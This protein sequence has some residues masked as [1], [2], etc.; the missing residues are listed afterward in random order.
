MDDEPFVRYLEDKVKSTI[1]KYG[2][3]GGGDRV[4]V[5]VSGGKDSTTALYVLKKL[6]Y[7]VE[8]I[9]IDHLLGEYSRKNLSNIQS[10][11]SECGIKLH[12][13]Y[14]REE[15]GYSTCYIKSVLN[16]K[17]VRVNQ[18]SI[19]GVMRR[20]I[21][22]RKARE[23]KASKIATGHNLDDE[24]QTVLMNMLKGNVYQSARLGPRAGVLDSGK[25]VPRIKPLY[26]CLEAETERYSRIHD[27]PVVYEPC[28]CSLDSFRTHVKK[29][30][31]GLEEENPG[32]KYS[33]INSFLEILPDLKAHESGGAVK[34]CEACG[35]PSSR[36]L[37]RV[38]EITGA[39]RSVS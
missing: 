32:V 11:C 30:L 28:P 31:N 20:S 22:N 7:N 14:M 37:C 21:L 12:V 18:C 3:I 33:I 38:C 1:E 26:F 35:E 8:G 10:F 19:C 24:V 39:M 6:G 29:L 4:L 23:L 2:L 13:V 34:E 36:R 15:Y 25:F 9:I 27:F 16:S 17:G 5:A